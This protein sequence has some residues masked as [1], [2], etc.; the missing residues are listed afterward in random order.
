MRLQMEFECFRQERL[1]YRPDAPWGGGA[2]IVE[3]E[4]SEE[5]NDVA[6]SPH[7]PSSASFNED[8]LALV[9]YDRNHDQPIVQNETDN[10]QKEYEAGHARAEG[11]QGS[12]MTAV[13]PFFM[14]VLPEVRKTF[15]N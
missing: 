6:N 8:E 11:S 15:A 14:G 9:I 4:D 10:T 2:W 7:T 12:R 1:D 3:I 5:G 13:R